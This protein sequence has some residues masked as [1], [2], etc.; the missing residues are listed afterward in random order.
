MRKSLVIASISML[1]QLSTFAQSTPDELSS[2]RE[3]ALSS[4][5]SLN[6]EDLSRLLQLNDSLR[7]NKIQWSL[8]YDSLMADTVSLSLWERAVVKMD[9]ALLNYYQLPNSITFFYVKELYGDFPDSNDTDYMRELIAILRECAVDVGDYAMAY[10]LQNK[11]QAFQY[12]TWKEREEVLVGRLDSLALASKNAEITGRKQLT[13]L[14]NTAM[15]WHLLAIASIII[16]VVLIVLFAVSK[17]RWSKQKLKLSQEV[18]DTSEKEILVAKLE[19]ARREIHELNVLVKRKVETPEIIREIQ[20]VPSPSAIKPQEIAEWNDQVQQ[21]LG[22]I[23]SHCEQGKSG[24]SVAT[25]MS[26]INDTT[27]LSAQVS[28]KSEEWISL[29]SSK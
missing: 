3:L 26:I 19:N 6:T 10:T 29:L 28:K 25:Y 27:R 14:G 13:D 9:D 20:Y 4:S 15:I 8:V 7:I 2:L 11:Q 24:M 18:N 16:V 22:K 5:A 21:V 1:F 23:K 17:A 12:D